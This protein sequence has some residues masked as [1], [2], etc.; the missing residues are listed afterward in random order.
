M[1]E[2]TIRKVFMI[3]YKFLIMK[4]PIF[5]TFYL[6]GYLFLLSSCSK[7]FDYTETKSLNLNQNFYVSIDEAQ[8]QLNSIISAMKDEPQ[9]RALRENDELTIASRYTYSYSTTRSDENE[10]TNLHVFN[11]SD[12]NG[13]AIMSA[14]KRVTPLL[15]LTSKGHLDIE[16]I[17]NT[18][19][20]IY[21]ERLE[22]YILNEIGEPVDTISDVIPY[23]WELSDPVLSYTTMKYGYCQVQWGQ[24]AP[25]NAYC[26]DLRLVGCVPLAVGQLL[27]IYKY[28][29]T[30]NGYSYNWT[31]MN[32]YHNINHPYAP[33]L[34]QICNIL[35]ELG[36]PSLL[37]ANYG[38]NGTSAYA[39]DIPQTL[40]NLGF[41]NGGTYSNYNGS[42]VLQE[43]Q[44]GYPLI[45]S[46]ARLENGEYIGHAF[47]IH[48]LLKTTTRRTDYDEYGN[49]I[50]VFD[51]IR[52]Y[53]LCNWGWGGTDDGFYLN[54]VFDIS[55][56][57]QY[58]W[59]PTND[60]NYIDYANRNYKYNVKMVT[61]IRK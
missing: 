48:G 44:K 46:G 21:V 24:D 8:S 19:L 9:T 7:E 41:A 56:G 34:P 23:Y 22:D 6:L 11:F 59:S 49:I 32:K 53:V 60:S 27:S 47:L 13:Y 28:P 58:N 43:L 29:Q 20:K 26:P 52:W 30:Y 54:G 36:K 51:R 42:T 25:Y 14:D 4:K 61:G 55:S 31:N 33:A 18:G 38:T 17:D 37:N 12:N 5:F 2:P 16:N 10:G 39:S 57:P 1:A 40:V 50:N 3:K 35:R 15:A 45:A